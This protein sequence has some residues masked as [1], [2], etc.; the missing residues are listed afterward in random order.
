MSRLA[1]GQGLLTRLA[2]AAASA[3]RQD[4]VFRGA[5]I[6]MGV[7]L[8]VFVLRPGV[9]RYDR[10][11]PPLETSSAGMPVLLNPAGRGAVRPV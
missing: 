7:I 6:G 8:A 1:A 9:S 10:V 4:M 11:L 5:V 3:W 2:E